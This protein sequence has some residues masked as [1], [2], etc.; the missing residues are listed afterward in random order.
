MNSN[1]DLEFY[2]V[3]YVVAK[4]LNI[5]KASEVLYVS[6]PAVTQTIKKL[7]EQLGGKLF[8]RQ[9]KGVALTEE[10]QNLFNFIKDGLESLENAA[11]RFAQYANLEVGT[12]KVKVGS[13]MGKAYAYDKISEFLKDYPNINIEI[14]GSSKEDYLPETEL[15]NG[16]IDM[17]FLSMPSETERENID[18]IE[19]YED[20]L[21]I[22]ASQEY[23]DTLDFEIKTLEDLSK[24]KLIVPKRNSNTRKVLDDFFESR[25]IEFEPDYQVASSL[26][27]L[28]LATNGVGVAIGYERFVKTEMINNKIKILDISKEL[29]STKIAVAT[30]KKDACSFVTRKFLEYIHKKK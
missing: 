25:N 11:S 28:S 26:A 1:I 24:V 3:F 4:Y 7:E 15:I 8:Y 27:R 10:G 29:P 23:L 17:V 21:V 13:T 22:F 6:Q 16:D 14:S 9:P 19:C 20:N 30:L 2:K 12:I 5:T 18:I